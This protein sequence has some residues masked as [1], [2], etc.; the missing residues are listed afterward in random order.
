MRRPP[1]RHGSALTAPPSVGLTRALGLIHGARVIHGDVK[2][3]NFLYSPLSKRVRLFDFDLAQPFSARAVVN[4][5]R[6]T[7]PY[8]APGT[9]AR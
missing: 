6:G 8:I 1:L 9:R 3:S 4:A 2:P 7:L 5:P